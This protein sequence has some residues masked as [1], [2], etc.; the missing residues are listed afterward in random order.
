MLTI[1]YSSRLFKLNQ[2]QTLSRFSNNGAI[3]KCKFIGPGVRF[4]ENKHLA[5]PIIESKY[6]TYRN[7]LVWNRR[8]FPIFICIYLIIAPGINP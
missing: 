2:L 4:T 7:A 3:V 6:I 5:H 1:C 8:I